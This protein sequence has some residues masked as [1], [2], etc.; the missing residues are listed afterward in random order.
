MDSP[1]DSAPGRVF[2]ERLAEKFPPIPESS[3]L[4]G[5]LS[6]D[7]ESAVRNK[8]SDSALAR[9]DGQTAE[10]TAYS[11]RSVL[12][13]LP[14]MIALEARFDDQSLIKSSCSLDPVGR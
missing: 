3:P 4:P 8:T 6:V 9:T 14:G 13:S 1:K 7:T 5:P 12:R 2:G 10:E 11:Q